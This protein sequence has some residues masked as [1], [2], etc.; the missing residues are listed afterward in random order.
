MI[1]HSIRPCKHREKGEDQGILFTWRDEKSERYLSGVARVERWARSARAS[2]GE[3]DSPSV[4][5]IIAHAY[6]MSATYEGQYEGALS[7]LATLLNT[8]DVRRHWSGIAR[9]GA[10]SECV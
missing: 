9:G 3:H 10:F 6:A 1:P 7:I 2:S 5:P 8:S 4:V